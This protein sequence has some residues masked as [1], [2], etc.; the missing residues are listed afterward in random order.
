MIT[1]KIENLIDRYPEAAKVAELAA[2]HDEN[3]PV[4][5]LCEYILNLTA[6]LLATEATPE[7]PPTSSQT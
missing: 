1:P 6:D 7:T 3:T 2:H 4:Y 5:I